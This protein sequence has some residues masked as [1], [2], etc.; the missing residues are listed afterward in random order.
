MKNLYFFL[1]CSLILLPM[2]TYAQAPT[3][4]SSNL[5]ISN[6]DGNSF[7]VSFTT[8]NGTQ[9]IIVMKADSPVTAIPAD[10][11]DYLAGSTFGTGNEIAPGEFVVYEGSSY[12]ASIIGL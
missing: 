7:S 1:L 6:I 10:G 8:G 4:P 9:R 2:Q 11:T 12:Y 3:T 5:A